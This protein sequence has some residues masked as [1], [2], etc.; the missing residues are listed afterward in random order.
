MVDAP[1]S[2]MKTRANSACCGIG[3]A[4]GHQTKKLSHASML[5]QLHAGS[6][7]ARVKKNPVQK[8]LMT[9]TRLRVHTRRLVLAGPA[10]RIFATEASPLLRRPRIIQTSSARNVFYEGPRIAQRRCSMVLVC[11]PPSESRPAFHGQ[12]QKQ[13][14]RPSFPGLPAGRGHCWQGGGRRG[15]SSN[16]Q[17]TPYCTTCL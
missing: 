15:S 11:P 9:G 7:Q 17:E 10:I 16:A 8:M 13:G 12:G 14:R 2:S 6:R 4:R 3:Q 5:W 1:Q